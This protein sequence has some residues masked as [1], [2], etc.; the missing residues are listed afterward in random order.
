MTKLLPL[1]LID[2]PIIA[3]SKSAFLN[4]KGASDGAH[5]FVRLVVLLQGLEAIE[6]AEALHIAGIERLV[7]AKSL[8]LRNH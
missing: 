7:I 1:T 2:I 8:H 4:E 6:Y 5:L 3:N